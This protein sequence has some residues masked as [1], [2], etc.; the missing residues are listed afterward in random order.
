MQGLIKTL[1]LF[2]AFTYNVSAAC[3]DR[4]DRDQCEKALKMFTLDPHGNFNPGRNYWQASCG[5]CVV[6]IEAEGTSNIKRFVTHSSGEGMSN[7]LTQIL[8]AEVNA[9]N[10]LMG[11]QVTI[12]N[13]LLFGSSYVPATLT[14]KMGDSPNTEE[15]EREINKSKAEV[16]VY[17]K[18]ICL[19][20][21]PS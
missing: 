1:V 17:T 4:L 12:V 11:K 13:P 10:P 3:K 15:S 8:N 18:S 5:T 21:T 19:D 16:Q 2:A 14:A 7:T 6:Y 9:C 20:F